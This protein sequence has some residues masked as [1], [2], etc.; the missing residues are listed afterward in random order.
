MCFLGNRR[1]KSEERKKFNRTF[2]VNTHHAAKK[3]MM[4]HSQRYKESKIFAV[5]RVLKRHLNG[6]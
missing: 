3:R 1:E 6:A 5:V 2:S 4:H